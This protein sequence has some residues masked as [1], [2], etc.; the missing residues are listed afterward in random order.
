MTIQALI[1]GAV[2]VAGPVG[3]EPTACELV[4]GTSAE[5]VL[6]SDWS[7][8]GGA[9]TPGA[10]R[11]DN[12]EGNLVMMVQ[13]LGSVMYDAVPI[14]PATPVDIGDRGRY[15]VG[16]SGSANVQFVRGEYSVTIRVTPISGPPASDLV[17]PLLEVARMA[18]ERMA[19]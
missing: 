19:G 1:L 13:I 12:A 9:S 14:N 3:Q 4:D 7:N 17:D 6:G 15:G 5:T 10:C 11:Y 2:L 16:S 18:A 8:P